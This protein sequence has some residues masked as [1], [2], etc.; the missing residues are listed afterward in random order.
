MYLGNFSCF[1][2]C[3]LTFQNYIYNMVSRKSFHIS[4]LEVKIID[5]VILTA[6]TIIYHDVVSGSDIKLCI[7]IHKPLV[8]YI[9][10]NVMQCWS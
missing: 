8:I 2:C 7:K 4:D 3:L 5:F 1:C 9:F 6:L 10:C